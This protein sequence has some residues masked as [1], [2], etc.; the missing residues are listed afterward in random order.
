MEPEVASAFYKHKD[1]EVSEH[2]AGI[3]RITYNG[4]GRGE[5]VVCAAV[6]FESAYFDEDDGV[7]VV[8]TALGLDDEHKRLA[9][10]KRYAIRY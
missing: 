4:K 6:L 1:L 2:C 10:L 3:V 7:P 9:F 8:V 5:K